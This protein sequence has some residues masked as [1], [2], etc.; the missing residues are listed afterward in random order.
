MGEAISP[1]CFGSTARRDA[2]AAQRAA[3]AHRGPPRHGRATGARAPGAGGIIP[4]GQAMGCTGP[5]PR[6]RARHADAAVLLHQLDL[7]QVGVLQDLRQR[8]DRLGIELDAAGH[9]SSSMASVAVATV[10][11]GATSSAIAR[12]ARA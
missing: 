4:A 3:A 10:A 1:G 8:A 7:G 11:S 9:S 2:A 12:S 6:Q 5:A